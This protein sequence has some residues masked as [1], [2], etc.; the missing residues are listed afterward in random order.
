MRY[1]AERFGYFRPAFAG[2]GLSRRQIL[3]QVGCGFGALAAHALLQ[4]SVSASGGAG[5]TSGDAAPPARAK[6]MIFLF[7]QGGVS[8]VDS[9]DHKP[10]LAKYDGQPMPFR[11]AR[12]LANTGQVQTEHRVMRSPWTFAR[13]GESG[14]W[15]SSLFPHIAGHAD[16][17]A[18]IHSMQTTGVAHGPATLFLHCGAT[19]LVR[20][21]LGSW[22][23]YGLGS[24]NDDLP[25]F[26]SVSPSAG[27]GGARNYGAAFLP[28]G[29]QGTPLGGSQTAADQLRWPWPEVEPSGRSRQRRQLELTQRLSRLQRREMVGES[30]L[31]AVLSSYE[32]GWRMQ[33]TAPQ[34]LDVERETEAT[35][36]LYGIGDPQTDAF[37]RKCLLARRMCEA[38]VRFVQVTYGDDTANPAWDQHSHLPKHADHALA[39]DRPVA[40][41]LTDLA[42]RGLLDDTLVWFGSE[43]GRTPYAQDN[44]T[45][46][47]HNPG[48]FTVWLAGGGVKPGVAWGATDEFG[49]QAVSGRVH[50]HDL[51]A[52]LL[53]LLGVD[54]RRLTFRHAGRDFRLTDV[55]G[56]VVHGLIG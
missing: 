41:L 13:H 12:K 21:S 11:D 18:M 9:F 34:L 1:S 40:G 47:D 15:F 27:N 53:H 44:G 33:Q 39:V 46:R 43:F 16:R 3:Q 24:E 51:H 30:E 35:R 20:P 19:N 55:H 56:R 10:L 5:G 8:Q 48:G 25:G 22:L 31:D 17:L 2:R 36:R 50:M 45:G 23:V 7:M 6:R 38:G 49:S 52:T 42:Q 14:Q 28:A 54:H 26:I 37:G 32:L 4:A 29:C